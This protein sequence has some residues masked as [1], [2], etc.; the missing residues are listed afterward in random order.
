MPLTLSPSSVQSLCRPAAS[1]SSSS[2]SGPAPGAAGPLLSPATL[3]AYQQ[4]ELEEQL[5]AAG[6]ILVT[7]PGCGLRVQ[8]EPEV[9]VSAYGCAVTAI[10]D[11][12]Q[13]VRL[14]D[15]T[16][17]H[18]DK[19]RL[20][21]SGCGINYCTG[22]KAVPY[23]LGKTCEDVAA[24]AKL[25]R[26]RFC[27]EPI[28]A[29]ASSSSAPAAPV[30]ID[31]S[32]D[33]EVGGAAA[34]VVA[35]GGGRSSG[36]GASAGRGSKSAAA[37]VSRSNSSVSVGAQP[38]PM[39]AI[40]IA[41]LS[42]N[43]GAGGAAAAAPAAGGKGGKGGKAGGSPARPKRA[44]SKAKG[45]G[46]A[47]SSGSSEDEVAAAP[48]PAK[49]AKGAAAGG[50]KAGA[51]A[52]A[53]PS[54]SSMVFLDSDGDDSAIIVC[55]SELSSGKGGSAARRGKGGAAAL[56][57]SSSIAVIEDDDAGSVIEAVS[58]STAAAADV[59]GEAAVVLDDV[60]DKRECQDR[61]RLMCPTTFPCKHACAGC[62]SDK[63]APERRKAAALEALKTVVAIEE[64]PAG[65]PKLPVAGAKRKAPLAAPV[66]PEWA[67]DVL[68]CVVRALYGP[69][70]QVPSAGEGKAGGAGAAAAPPPPPARSMRSGAAKAAAAAAAAAA[71]P[72][73]PAPPP[74]PPLPKPHDVLKA[75]GIPPAVPGF[76][77]CLPC[78]DESC[79]SAGSASSSSSSA[80]SGG[81]PPLTDD[82]DS[83]CN[84]CYIENLSQAPCLQLRC[85]HAFHHACITKRL[86][87]RWTGARITFNFMQCPLCKAEVD[88]PALLDTL[89]PLWT[90]R[91]RVEA[92]AER[93][94]KVEGLDKDP[95][96]T[97][98]DSKW[99]GKPAA[100]AMERCSYALCD[101]CT[102]PFFT[103]LKA[104]GDGGGGGGGG[105]AGGAAAA[106]MVGGGYPAGAL[107][108]AMAV[109]GGGFAAIL[110]DVMG[111]RMVGGMG[112][113]GGYDAGLGGAAANAPRAN[114]NA[115]NKLLCSACTQPPPGVKVC[116][117][118]GSDHMQ[119]KCRYCCSLAVW[120]CYQG[121][122]HATHFC[123]PCHRMAGTNI[124]ARVRAGEERFRCKG[125]NGCPLG[126]KHAPNGNEDTLGCD[127]CRIN[128]DAAF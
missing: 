91:A 110:A 30:M 104:C 121:S 20:R 69:G 108:A 8:H 11:S 93:R 34:R 86:S 92:M 40:V 71:A 21:C 82:G 95:Q 62:A 87:T 26:C 43:G 85:G 96:Y 53:A 120:Y 49:R 10:D 15:A 13:T 28:G 19:H 58:S 12:G 18:R 94:M 29:P 109:A 61:A 38:G 9:T 60:C 47:V 22:C 114:V 5:K 115:D 65:K 107:G 75:L 33:D 101:E 124:I 4:L 122:P 24:V 51:A 6:I 126:G 16:A 72:P 80:A 119:Y 56:T 54:K 99:A 100:F 79:F 76:G 37:A 48:P 45:K 105:G 55:G 42:G 68:R 63:L 97:A 57:L 74:P 23:H 73:A 7:C 102:V 3:E 127:A 78:L 123:E 113:A 41:A 112:G 52:A 50:R 27:T 89:L 84:I 90:L 125:V 64:K 39:K 31:L 106:A 77:A 128:S 46:A 1:S 98:P 14:T 88:H 25:K 70:V 83:L 116:P 111:G 103:G 44:S 2:S 35:S 66:K 17:V 36:R 32:S 81:F 67:L 59:A 117:T 118:H